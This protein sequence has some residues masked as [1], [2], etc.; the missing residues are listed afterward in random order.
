[1]N[2]VFTEIEHRTDLQDTVPAADINALM[3][4]DAYL[5]N[6]IETNIAAIA[7]LNTELLCK[8]STLYCTGNYTQSVVDPYTEFK[9]NCASADLTHTLPTP[10]AN[11]RVRISHIAGASYKLIVVAADG[12]AIL[13]SDMMSEIWLPCVG[14]WAEF[15]YIA[16]LG[17]WELLGHKITCQIKL[18]TYAG[19]GSTD[20]AIIRMTNITQSIGNM[21]TE[22]HSAGYASNTT[23]L[24]FTIK[25]S[26]DYGISGNYF[27]NYG[28]SAGLSLNA[29]S[30]LAS[31]ILSVPIVNRL[32]EV[33]GGGTAG[34]SV[35]SLMAFH[36]KRRF[37]K[38]DIIRFHG[39]ATGPI[40]AATCD[41]MMTFL[42]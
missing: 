7:T 11:Q 22:N 4:N 10:V 34:Q 23:G 32:V 19:Y 6:L 42:G 41:I 5:K 21:V 13:S 27:G 24:A 26:G 36:V 40:S 39:D 12:S 33:N 37:E 35:A 29:T 1:M 3:G 18:D 38:N 14:D 30:Y 28:A 15:Q 17:L 16:S 9:Y 31:N 20:T 25:K 2:D 8:P